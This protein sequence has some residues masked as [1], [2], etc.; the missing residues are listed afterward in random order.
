VQLLEKVR[1]IQRV[2]CPSIV[3]PIIGGDGNY[4]VEHFAGQREDTRFFDGSRLNKFLASGK[5]WSTGWKFECS[6]KESPYRWR[7]LDRSKP[8]DLAVITTAEGTLPHVM[9]PSPF[10]LPGANAPS[11]AAP[12]ADA[13]AAA[14]TTAAPAADSPAITAT[15][16]CT[17]SV[18]G[19]PS[20]GLAV[21][22]DC[23]AVVDI[24]GTVHFSPVVAVGGAAAA[25][26]AADAS[27]AAAGQWPTP[28]AGVNAARPLFSSASGVQPLPI[29]ASADGE[30]PP[31]LLGPPRPGAT[32]PV[33]AASALPI[34]SAV[35]LP[36]G[37]TSH[38]P[39]ASAMPLPS[40]TP[41]SSQ[42]PLSKALGK[43]KMVPAEEAAAAVQAAAELAAAVV[44]TEYEQRLVETN[45]RH[46]VE[47]EAL[48]EENARQSERS[49][50]V[51][52]ESQHLR[53][54]LDE[55]C[56]QIEL[57][58]K[59]SGNA[60]FYC[61]YT[62]SQRALNNERRAHKVHDDFL[63]QQLQRATERVEALLAERELERFEGRHA[64]DVVTDSMIGE[65]EALREQLT[66][67]AA[68]RKT[69]AG[70]SAA[71]TTKLTS[72]H[73]NRLAEHMYTHCRYKW[74]ES[75]AIC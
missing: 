39:C 11:E 59:A 34:A 14:P 64:S 50:A 3:L 68:A 19:L 32:P 48:R 13:P 62:E 30:G 75:V 33:A 16:D 36:D 27:A 21:C 9:P 49:C 2:D 54:Q 12:S 69:L 29:C 47:I 40:T 57:M 72:R 8:E 41:P 58:T 67:K 25:V 28:D 15:A 71:P 70:A 53:E 66:T 73:V 46:H 4:Y 17:C 38:L 10:A 6:Q 43:Q 55:A 61:L 56:S 42:Q 65:G 24:L 5:I 23:S 31:G 18:C 74:H 20:L 37:Q 26:A 1:F 44:S 63:T 45:K 52:D 7:L 35:P 60:K 22:S 51:E